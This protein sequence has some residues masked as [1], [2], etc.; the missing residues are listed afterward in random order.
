MQHT[1]HCSTLHSVLHKAKSLYLILSAQSVSTL[2]SGETGVLPEF[3]T[4]NGTVIEL[5]KERNVS[6][7]SNVGQVRL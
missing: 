6:S 1:A 4:L 3:A 7:L 2:Y 5:G